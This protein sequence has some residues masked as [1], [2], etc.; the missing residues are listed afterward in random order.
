MTPT[1]RDLAIRL[2]E[3]VLRT[4]KFHEPSEENPQT[5]LH[6]AL[7]DEGVLASITIRFEKI[8]H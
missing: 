2:L 1:Q 7:A 3:S 6:G 8:V 4:V 5:S